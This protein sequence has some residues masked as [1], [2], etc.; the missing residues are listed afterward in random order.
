MA[1]S[2]AIVVYNAEKTLGACLQSVADLTDD[3]VVVVDSRT[4]DQTRAVAQRYTDRI[5]SRDFD[6][7]AALKNYA[8]SLTK[9]DWVLSMDADERL[10]AGLVGEIGQAITQTAYAGFFIPRQNVIWGREMSHTNW[11]SRS[12]AHVWLFNK[13][14]SSWVGTV[15]EHVQVAGRLGRLSHPKIH[16]N[17]ATVEQFL[18]KTNHYTTLEAAI[19]KFSP[20]LLVVHPLWKFIRHYV[21]YLGFLDG[22]HGLFA[23]YLMAIYGLTVHVKAWQ[24]TAS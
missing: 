13:T 7:F 10:S 21:V 19:R 17:Y 22:W 3:I 6:N 20:V 23:S 1:V 14:A 8:V 4:T 18:D 15:H 16:H 11:S 9:H 24:K 12:D 5:F 2:V